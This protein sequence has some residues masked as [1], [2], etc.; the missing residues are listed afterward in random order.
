MGATVFALAT[1]E[2]E[3]GERRFEFLYVAGAAGEIAI[4]AVENLHRSF[5]VDGAKIDATLWRPNHGDAFG[6]W[7]FGHSPRPNSRRMSS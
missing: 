3:A 2:A 4:H 1:A 6:R 7:Q 5:A